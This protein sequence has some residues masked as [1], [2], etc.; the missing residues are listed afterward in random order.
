[1][2]NVN[3]GGSNQ[4]SQ[5]AAGVNYTLAPKTFIFFEGKTLGVANGYNDAI[6]FGM[7]TTF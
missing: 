3:Y 1:M 7:R 5:C 6:E 2:Q 4:Y